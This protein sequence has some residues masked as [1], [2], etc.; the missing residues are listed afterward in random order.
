MK[1]ENCNV[2]HA[3]RFDI[4]PV[5]LLSDSKADRLDLSLL[6][7]IPAAGMKVMVKLP[8]NQMRG[9]TKATVALLNISCITSTA[10]VIPG[11][12]W[13]RYRSKNLR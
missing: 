2:A 8:W 1:D 6:V 7:S 12:P 10:K 4:A 13:C 3:S 11:P 5:T 9:V